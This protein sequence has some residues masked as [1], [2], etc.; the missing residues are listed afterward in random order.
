MPNLSAPPPGISSATIR[1]WV[2][3]AIATLGFALLLRYG[4]FQSRVVGVIC[5]AADRPWWCDLRDALGMIH[6]FWIW[7]W[8]G[9]GVAAAGF[10]LG[11]RR[12]LGAGLVLS[13]LGLVVYNTELG[14]AGL[15]LS[16]LGAATQPEGR[17]MPRS[18][19]APSA[20]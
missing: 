16:L 13:I 6:G 9:F 11:W 14:A 7:G 15:I 18:R 10:W 1:R 4:F 2:L 20:D 8:A 12:A 5:L 17:A 19:A 3:S